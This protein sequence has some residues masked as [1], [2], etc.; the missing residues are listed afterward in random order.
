MKAVAAAKT[1]A[2]PEAEVAAAAEVATMS[3]TMVAERAVEVTAAAVAG[4]GAKGTLVSPTS[5]ST[6]SS[7]RRSRRG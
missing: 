7:E 3:T 5:R 1:E 4:T 2:G 6:R